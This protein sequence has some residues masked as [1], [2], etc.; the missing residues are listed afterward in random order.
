MIIVVENKGDSALTVTIKFD[1][2]DNLRVV[3]QKLKK[4]ELIIEVPANSSSYKQ[5][6][7]IDRNHDCKA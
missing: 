2:L 1:D 7:A 3:G 5:L 6:E 4:D